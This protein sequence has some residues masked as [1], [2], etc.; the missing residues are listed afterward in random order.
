M[1]IFSLSRASA[2]LFPEIKELRQLEKPTESELAA[3]LNDDELDDAAYSILPYPL[4]TELPSR[5]AAPP[6]ILGPPERIEIE[7]R[8]ERDA[9]G[10]VTSRETLSIGFNAQGE[11][12]G[13]IT[14]KAQISRDDAGLISSINSRQ[15]VR[16]AAGELVLSRESS[17]E[18][19]RDEEG[20]LSSSSFSAIVSDAEGKVLRSIQINVSVE[21]DEAGEIT[22]R[23]VERSIVNNEPEREARAKRPERAE[24]KERPE[25][26]ER[27]EPYRVP[28]EA[29]E[30]RRVFERP[31]FAQL[32]SG[33]SPFNVET[34]TTSAPGFNEGTN[35]AFERD[36]LALS[37]QA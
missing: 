29:Q 37:L 20:R 34:R 33:A 1:D 3:G 11:E 7:E 6:E 19:S 12:V 21:R 9:A 36:L 27:P 10:A 15:E 26:I 17:R 14:R 5:E 4:P 31:E 8:I 18:I 28:V 24:K 16:N 25:G 35:A 32:F 22:A 2:E 30:E 13:S 23:R